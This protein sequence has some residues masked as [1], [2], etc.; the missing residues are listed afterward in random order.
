DLVIVDD[1]SS[2]NNE[3]TK[4]AR[5]KLIHWFNSV[6]I[7]IGGPNT[8]F[9][10]VGTMVSA[11]G[12]LNHVLHRRDFRASYHDAIFSEPAH[13]ELWQEYCEIYARGTKEEADEFY[14]QHKDKLEE[15][16]QVAWPWRWSYRALMHEKV[17]MGTRAF[18]SEYRNRAYSEDEQFFR[19]E[20]FAYYRYKT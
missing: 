15:G 1:P 6:V 4:E 16:V 5:E 20:N 9:I 2:Q 11:T 8:A 3:G 14:E 19:P 18:N 13:P 10:V 7:P 12:L 17:N